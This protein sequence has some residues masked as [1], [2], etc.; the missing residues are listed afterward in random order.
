MIM[1]C[2]G[3]AQAEPILL[4]SIVDKGGLGGSNFDG[5]DRIEFT[6]ALEPEF[7]PLLTPGIGKG[8]FW[9]ED[10]IGFV[11]LTE[12]NDPVFTKFA[13]LI[14]NGVDNYFTV[15]ASVPGAGGGGGGNVESAWLSQSP[16]V[17][18]FGPDFAGYT[19][20]FVRLNVTELNFERIEPEP[21]LF[22]DVEFNVRFDFYGT[23]V[24]E[25]GAFVFGEWTIGSGFGGNGAL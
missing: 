16:L 12:M 17:P 19:L 15:F 21:G 22:I 9:M 1:V 20:D 2:C 13:T 4:A 24:P 6:L 3:A 14:T 5:A 11:D 10:N 23:S 8:I 7:T 18:E 25:P